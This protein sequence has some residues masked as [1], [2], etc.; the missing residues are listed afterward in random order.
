[1]DLLD[2]EKLIKRGVV[3][4]AEWNYEPLLGWIQHMRFQVIWSLLGGQR[5][6]RLLEVG[7]GSGVFML[8]LAKY[9]SELHGLDVH[10][11]S[12]KGQSIFAS[13][14]IMAQLESGS[15]ENAIYSDNDFDCFV[16]VSVLEFV[17][18]LPDACRELRHISKRG[19]RIMIDT[20]GRSVIVDLG[21]RHLTGEGADETFEDR[22]RNLI[23]EL[24]GRSKTAVQD[25]A[26]EVFVNDRLRGKSKRS[27]GYS[28]PRTTGCLRLRS[29]AEFEKTAWDDR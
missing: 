5:F 15:I 10:Q 18:N 2:K 20:P 16:I 28:A 14:G 8:E 21:F 7:Y 22:S 13:D 9:C 26:S 23:P 4:F 24:L 17:E 12:Q 1:M 6:E 27:R 3:D 11:M 29:I 25:R 19:G